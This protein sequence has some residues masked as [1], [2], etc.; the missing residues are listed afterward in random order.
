MI[1]N[2]EK[3]S[4]LFDRGRF[5]LPWYPIRSQFPNCV[6]P[7]LGTIT[8]RINIKIRQQYSN[9][10][11][12]CSKS[13]GQS[14]LCT[15]PKYLDHGHFPLRHMV[16]GLEI[17]MEMVDFHQKQWAYWSYPSFPR[18]DHNSKTTNPKPGNHHVESLDTLRSSWSVTQTCRKIFKKKPLVFEL[19]SRPRVSFK[20]PQDIKDCSATQPLRWHEVSLASSLWI[21]RWKTLVAFGGKQ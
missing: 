16:S 9:Y 11:V 14:S 8:W 18:G 3:S 17:E 10:L 2:V 1:P 7:T 5:Y 4:L 13:M 15:S 21:H 12:N 6:N 19:K 20:Y